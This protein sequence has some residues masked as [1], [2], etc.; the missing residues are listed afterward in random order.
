MST[1]MCTFI[2]ALLIVLEEAFASEAPYALYKAVAVV[3]SGQFLGHVLAVS[4]QMQRLE[5]CYCQITKHH[6]LDTES[7]TC[8]RY[9][10]WSVEQSNLARHSAPIQDPLL[11]RRSWTLFL[12]T[13]LCTTPYHN[14]GSKKR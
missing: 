6:L 10:I 11:V 8:S 1:R 5:R 12:F 2:I 4:A 3:K 14:I 9:H 7:G 13:A